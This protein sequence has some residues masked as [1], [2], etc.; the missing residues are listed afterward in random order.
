MEALVMFAC[1]EKSVPIVPTVVEEVLK[2]DWLATVRNVV[3]ALVSVVCPVTLRVLER[4]SAVAE[5]VL[6]TV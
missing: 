4:V 5:A 6:S 2:T 1:V 3:E